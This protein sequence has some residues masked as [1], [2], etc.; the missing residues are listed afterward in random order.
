MVP[1]FSKSK[2]RTSSFLSFQAYICYGERAKWINFDALESL[3]LGLTVTCGLASRFSV[4]DWL[5]NS[6]CPDI[7]NEDVYSY[8]KKHR[9]LKDCQGIENGFLEHFDVEILET[10]AGRIK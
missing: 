10:K 1:V 9:D 6:A 3:Q 4:V 7:T 2:N 8:F 5:T